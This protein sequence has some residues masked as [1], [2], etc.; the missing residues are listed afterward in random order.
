MLLMTL[1]QA[2]PLVCIV[3]LAVLVGFSMVIRRARGCERSDRCCSSSP[4]SE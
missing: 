4:G 2:H 3:A 1:F